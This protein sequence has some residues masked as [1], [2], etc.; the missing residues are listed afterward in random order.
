MHCSERLNVNNNV[1]REKNTSGMLI[2]NSW[3]QRND[4]V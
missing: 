4:T 1:M 3:Y 2:S